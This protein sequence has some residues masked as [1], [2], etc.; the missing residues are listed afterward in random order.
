MVFVLASTAYVLHLYTP[1]LSHS[2]PS[3]QHNN[4]NTLSLR[5][6]DA[7]AASAYSEDL[8]QQND[9][10]QVAIAEQRRKT[11]NLDAQLKQKQVSIR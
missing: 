3:V 6:Q 8:Q 10:Y 7:Y 9:K 5:P 11:A 2:S 1:C 4:T